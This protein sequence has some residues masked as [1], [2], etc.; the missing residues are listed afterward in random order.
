MDA[1]SSVVLPRPDSLFELAEDDD[2]EDEEDLAPFEAWDG[3]E[4]DGDEKDEGDN[5]FEL[6][7][8]DFQD[9]EDGVTEEPDDGDSGDVDEETFEEMIAEEESENEIRNSGPFYF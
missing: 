5:V 6:D 4:E 7:D 1:P 2:F 3:E 9:E 8:D